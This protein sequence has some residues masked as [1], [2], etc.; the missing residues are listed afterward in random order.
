MAFCAHPI[1]ALVLGLFLV[2]PLLANETAVAFKAGGMV[3]KKSQHLSMFSELLEISLDNIQVSYVFHNTTNKDIVEQIAFPL[4][5]SPY[6]MEGD[7]KLTEM[8]QDAVLKAYRLL[9]DNPQAVE[10]VDV[11]RQSQQGALAPFVNFER[12]VN[13]IAMPVTYRMQ[14]LDIKHKDITALLK[15]HQIPLSMV[16]WGA[17]ELAKQPQL[18]EK[19]EQL[20]LLTS[21]GR[22]NWKLQ[23][24]YLWTQEFQAGKPLSV[25]HKYRPQV[26]HYF[27][28][29]HVPHAK[30]QSLKDVRLV[31]SDI[32]NARL[33]DYCFKPQDAQKL[34]QLI[35]KQ[36]PQDAPYTIQEIRYVLKTGANWK[37]PIRR[38]R[39]E[40]KL[41]KPNS[42]VGLNLKGFVQKREGEK[43]VVDLKNFK[44]QGDL[45]ILIFSEVPEE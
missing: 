39:L 11:P 5:L 6:G 33:S 17:D 20:H 29:P 7:H 38:F 25:T 43:V 24:T 8:V 15:S 4:P 3:F 32:S 34:L 12:N 42:L 19:L 28:V 30:L 1:F 41:P 44:P 37:G 36:D 27:L 31:G 35:K 22:P 21:Q 16:Y 45:E 26:G 13:N 18:V 10:G 14:A 40:I 2:K 9:A 23:T